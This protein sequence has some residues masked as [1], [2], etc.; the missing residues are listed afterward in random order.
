MGDLARQVTLLAKP[1]F[2]FLI[3]TKWFAMLCKEMYM[4]EKLARQE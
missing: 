1:T 2:L 3:F 4:Y